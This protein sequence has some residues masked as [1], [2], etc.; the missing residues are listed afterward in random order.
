MDFFDTGVSTWLSNEWILAWE[1]LAYGRSDKDFNDFVVMIES[2][3]QFPTPGS[4]AL[5]S[6]G[7]IGIAMVRRKRIV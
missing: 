1:D 5:L 4:L 6:I 7:L 3:H 2:V